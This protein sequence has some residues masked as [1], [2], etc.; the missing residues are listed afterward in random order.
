MSELL[1]ILNIK[2][3]TKENIKYL[4][5]ENNLEKRKIIAEFSSEIRVNVQKDFH[6]SE[7]LIE[8]S[9]YCNAD[10]TFCQSRN[11]NTKINRFRLNREE[12]IEEAVSLYK[13]GCESIL[14]HS[15]YDDFYNTDRI[16]YIIYSIKKKV[17]IKITMSLGLRELS[18][19]KVWKIA[20]ADSYFL[21]FVTQSDE[22]YH[23]TNSWDTF[24]NRINHIAELK[25]LGYNVG[26]G[27]IIGLPNQTLDDLAKDI[28]SSK[29][30]DV[31]YINFCRYSTI[32]TKHNDLS[33][34]EFIKRGLEVAQIIIPELTVGINNLLN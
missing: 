5:S 21:N 23:K 28:L 13:S 7:K 15:G 10:C 9:N 3:F 32:R 12:I 8:I 2:D 19:Y 6:H 29:N 1:E 30:L 11:D 24:E 33:S 18:E 31:D 16:A 34:E 22:M 25:R 20:G 4:L 27:S 26:S 17:N 14:I